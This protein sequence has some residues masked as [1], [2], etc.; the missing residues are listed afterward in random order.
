MTP[1]RQSPFVIHV[2]PTYLAPESYVGGG[3][4]FVDELARAMALE[5]SVKLVSFGPRAQRSSTS[6]GY[7]RV[8]LRNWTREKITPFSPWLAD[9]L[10]GADV[11]HCHQYFTLST[12]MAAWYGRLQGSRVFVTDLGGGGWTPGYQIDISRWIESHL[13]LSNYSALNLPGENK[14]FRVIGGG[15]DLGR[16]TMRPRMQHDGSLVFL[17][18]IL[19]HKGIHYLLAALPAQQELHVIGPVGDVEYL[20]Q[21]KSMAKGKRVVFRHDLDDDKVIHRL[22][23]AMALVHPTPV[24]VHG[25][26]RANEFF[27]LALVEAMACGCPV[28]ASAVASLPEIVRDGSCGFLVPPNDPGAI[29]ARIARLSADGVNWRLMSAAARARA[30]E[31]EWARVASAC[32]RAYTGIPCVS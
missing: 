32:L 25:D 27:G 6:L 19:P 16:F 17:G 10:R 28:I 18:R 14:R 21:L 3:E 5:V 4:R 24:D 30:E 1:R 22:Q 9:E 15:V 31:F 7:E 11:V 13:P 2:S 29:A 26:A 12:F 23:S 20:E 8:V